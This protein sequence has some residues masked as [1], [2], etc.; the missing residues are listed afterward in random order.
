MRND[1]RGKFVFKGYWIWLVYFE[2]ILITF[3]SSLI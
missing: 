3:V 1:W 2:K